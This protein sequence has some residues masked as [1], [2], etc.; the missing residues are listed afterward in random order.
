MANKDVPEHTIKWTKVPVGGGKTVR[1]MKVRVKIPAHQRNSPTDVRTGQAQGPKISTT[2]PPKSLTLKEKI[3]RRKQIQ[4][5][6]GVEV[7]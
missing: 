7:R 2:K 6:H 4:R 1:G 3:E 5:K